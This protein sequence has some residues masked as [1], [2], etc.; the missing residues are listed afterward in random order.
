MTD[1]QQP[2]LLTEQ[3]AIAAMDGLIRLVRDG[4]QCVG[5]DGKPVVIEGVPQMKPAPPAYYAR[6]QA[7]LKSRA[8]IVGRLSPSAPGSRPG[9]SAAAAALAEMA[10]PARAALASLPD[11]TEGEDP[12]SQ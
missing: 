4:I 9:L 11:V 3:D 8:D 12:A 5:P 2:T 7:W 6:L 1:Q 10:S